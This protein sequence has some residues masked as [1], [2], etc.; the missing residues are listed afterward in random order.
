MNIS[1]I[2]YFLETAKCLNLTKAAQNLFIT[3]PTLGRQLIKIE[4]ELNVLLFIRSNKGLTLT[5][6]GTVLFQEFSKLIT[7]YDTAVEKASL[8]SQCIDGTLNI[9]VLDGLDVSTLIP[10][11]ISYF[12]TNHPNIEIILKRESFFALLDKL[13]QHKL[14]ASITFAFH[15][16]EMPD[17]SSLLLKQSCPAF[18]VPIKHPL[19]QKETL[20]FSDFRDIPLAIVKKRECPS[21]VDLIIDSFQKYADFYP[22]LHFLD[23]MADVVLWVESGLRCAVLNVDMDLRRS[24]AVKLFPFEDMREV[25]NIELAYSNDNHNFALTLLKDYYAQ[26]A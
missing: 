17:L 10:D 3:Q 9:G 1:Q 15:L 16:S 5:P 23:S 24:E 22:K 21:G 6:A 13:N 14:D 11:L 12:E 7:D 26:K 18:V 19:A 20:T 4:S 25:N 8:A 2:R